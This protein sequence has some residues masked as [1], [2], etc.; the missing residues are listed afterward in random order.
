MYVNVSET[1]ADYLS[2]DEAA[3][4]PTLEQVAHF[5]IGAIARALVAQCVKGGYP[6]DEDFL[7]RHE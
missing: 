6:V 7:R 2:Y 3:K 4:V 1:E 5:Q